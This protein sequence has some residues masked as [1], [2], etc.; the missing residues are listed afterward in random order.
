MIERGDME[1]IFPDEPRTFQG[2]HI[3]YKA[4][5]LASG[6]QLSPFSAK[7]LYV[8]GMM[9]HLLESAGWLLRHQSPFYI[10][11]Y[12][13][14]CSA[15]EIFA[16]C[17]RG[18]ADPEDRQATPRLKRGLEEIAKTQI[19]N[20][21]D[22]VAVTPYRNYTVQDCVN[23]RNF[24]AHG[25]GTPGSGSDLTLDP[26][27]L[28]KML[29]QTCSAM[30]CYYMRFRD[31]SDTATAVRDNLASAA[32]LPLFRSDGYVIHVNEMYKHIVTSG[33]RPGIGLLYEEVW[34]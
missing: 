23:L 25:A 18:D 33:K 7:A 28:H 13:L 11:A 12:L 30:D 14:I 22:V 3:W 5:C 34:R 10:S 15:L 27:L 20:D 31:V 8:F 19:G 2:Q 21:M 1:Q 16:R 24:A 17:L 26:L 29:L 4:G 9:R 32:I 6:I